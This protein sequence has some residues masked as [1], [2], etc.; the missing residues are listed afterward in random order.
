[1]L[2]AR[3]DENE[4][5]I[6]RAHALVAEAAEDDRRIAPAGEW[7]IDNFYLIEEQVRTARQ[8][9][10]SG[11]SRELPVIAAGRGAGHPRAYELAIELI[12]HVDGRLELPALEAFVAAYQEHQALKLGELWAVPIML[13]L[14]LIENLRRVCAGLA[15]ARRDRDRAALWA[16]RIVAASAKTPERVVVELAEL[17]KESPGLSDAFAAEFSRRMQAAGPRVRVALGWLEQRLA[18]QGRSLEQAVQAESRRQA[19]DQVSVGNSVGSMR[20][21]GSVDWKTFVERHAVVER[22]LRRD[23]AGVYPAQDFASRDAY[24]DF[25]EKT[26]RRSGKPEADVAKLAVELASANSD[27]ADRRA[28]HV[29]TYLV[30]PR[31]AELERRAGARF[32]PVG[33]LRRFAHDHA[34]AIFLGTLAAVAAV[35]T[36]ALLQWTVVS[37][38]TWV[39]VA[40]IALPLLIALSQWG[41]GFVNWLVT[42]FVPPRRL[43]RLDFE[44]GIPAEYRTAVAVP[45]MLTSPDGVDDLLSAMEVRFLANRDPEL[46]FV[47]LSDFADHKEQRRAD[48]EALVERA[49]A[50]TRRL[51]E[52]YGEGQDAGGG[53]FVL[54]HRP[55][56]FNPA[57]GPAGKWMG[58]ERKRGKLEDFNALLLD[59]EGVEPFETVVGDT[60]RLAGT[61]YVICLDSDTALPRGAAAELVGTMAHPLNRPVIDPQRR[62]VIDGYGL[63]QPRAS[64][65]MGGRPRNAFVEL[66]AGEPGVDPYTRAV[67]DVYQDAFREGS[68]IGKGI[69]DVAAFHKTLGN[70]LPD[71]RILS[72][73]LLEGAHVRS[74]LVS[75]VQVYEDYPTSYLVDMGRRHRW[76]RGDWQIAAW[77]GPTVPGAAGGGGE[78]GGTSRRRSRGGRCSTTC[79]GRSSRRRC[80]WCWGSAGSGTRRWRGRCS[81]WGS[82]SCR[83]HLTCS[84]GWRGGSA[85]SCRWRCTSAPRCAARPG[86]S[87]R[88]S[89][90]WPRCRSRRCCTSTRS[91]G[92]SGE[93]GCRSGTSWSGPRPPTRRGGRGRTWAGSTW[94]CGQT[95]RSR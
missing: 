48:D 58:R 87:G 23:P 40:L 6:A 38:G 65:S 9:L 22:A 67:S 17:V 10:P 79:G 53:P 83:R 51:N 59:P 62:L 20:W 60:D 18:D 64:V 41:V 77:A 43:P 8:H 63:L 88:R 34:F 39:F 31:R 73:D 85:G 4:R 82:C 13:R 86:S 72:H 30:G 68:F 92:R 91:R 35:L 80:C 70:R 81:G 28:A 56:L 42:S 12:S 76:V 16:E 25:V 75:D 24:R 19:G 93:S 11:Y 89:S 26:A 61:T 54:L 29:G 52:V 78:R 5:I 69:Y 71:N 90:A 47:L 33:R 21:L 95:R 37:G 74:G 94:R 14:A 27:R 2:L 46:T 7:L 36:F 3:L 50:G 1:M 15:Q 84:S 45:C 55:R 44:D 57:E 49:A 66:F 32:S